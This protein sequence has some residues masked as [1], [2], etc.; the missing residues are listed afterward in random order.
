MISVYGGLREA[1][2]II[3]G[4][5]SA[6]SQTRLIDDISEVGERLGDLIEYIEK[7]DL[8]SKDPKEIQG[9]LDHLRAEIDSSIRFLESL[10]HDITS[11]RVELGGPSDP[12]A[13]ALKGCIEILDEVLGRIEGMI[14]E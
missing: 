7:E 13:E 1:F 2:G 5:V 4:I 12:T 11:I 8:F 10:V 6:S 14:R 9:A 3:T